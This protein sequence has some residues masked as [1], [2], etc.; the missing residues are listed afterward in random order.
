MIHDT[1]LTR[2]SRYTSRLSHSRKLSCHGRDQLFGWQLFLI[3]WSR[4]FSLSSTQQR[5]LNYVRKR[6][7]HLIA[8]CPATAWA[9]P[10]IFGTPLQGSL[11]VW[12]A[13]QDTN[14]FQE[15][16]WLSVGSKREAKQIMCRSSPD[17]GPAV[18]GCS[19]H[20]ATA[21]PTQRTNKQTTNNFNTTISAK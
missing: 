5:G 1:G 10:R 9:R 7:K 15:A 18:E 17:Y 11:L 16:H 4:L 14:F 21:P 20:H 13:R 6:R 2:V 12:S 8:E 3:R 19:Q